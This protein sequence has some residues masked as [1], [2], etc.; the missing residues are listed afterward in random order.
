MATEAQRFEQ[1]TEL[2]SPQDTQDLAP[3]EKEMTRALEDEYR[4]CYPRNNYGEVS[5]TKAHSPVINGFEQALQTH[6][7][8]ATEPSGDDFLKTISASGVDD[9]YITTSP[10]KPQDST[11]KTWENHQPQQLESYR[12]NLSL[13]KA[14]LPH[15][16]INVP[17]P[18][19]NAYLSAIE[20][21]I[22]FS[23]YAQFIGNSEFTQY[24]RT[25]EEWATLIDIEESGTRNEL[26]LRF[27]DHARETLERNREAQSD[28]EKMTTDQAFDFW[29]Y[30]VEE[31]SYIQGDEPPQENKLT[32]HQ[33][34]RK[35]EVLLKRLELDDWN[36]EI[37]KGTK[38]VSVN[39]NG[40][41]IKFPED[42]ELVGREMIYIPGHEFVHVT[43]GANGFKQDCPLLG[44]G[45]EGYLPTEE[46]LASMAEMILGQPYGHRRQA[47]FAARYLSVAM[48][49]KTKQENNQIVPK[50]SLQDIYTT[51]RDYN[52]SHSDA[53]QTVWRITR[54]TSM[55]HQ[56]TPIEVAT[57]NHVIQIPVA[58]TFVKDAV[59]FEGYMKM[60]EFFNHAAPLLDR[61]LKDG[62]AVIGGRHV[63]DFS[64]KFKARVGR[65][66]ASSNLHDYSGKKLSFSEAKDLH[67]KYVETGQ[68]ALINMLQYFI[69]GGKMTFE[70]A[71]DPES[72]WNMYLKRSP[73]DGIV[74]FQ[75]LLSPRA[76]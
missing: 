46:G 13:L 35:F 47:L 36:V 16:F 30:T 19:Q 17:T 5:V 55:Q 76:A 44:T 52:I 15:K 18:F 10:V 32:P 50:Y 72:P 9:I 40:K 41:K 21:Q 49:L 66:L 27:E 48:S 12:R 62:E 39:A 24:Q 25:P 22:N 57:K 28:D 34:K 64:L 59:Y 4:A 54:G 53:A 51:L 61:D 56:V 65:A 74:K 67:K 73:E 2:V 11:L 3:K 75:D 31:R 63:K 7:D 45:M 6:Y 42:R 68:D 37:E 33:G 70:S 26:T 71:L 38:A 60:L 29:N 69:D 1:Y 23:E 20:N 58:E 8:N 14:Q 43:R